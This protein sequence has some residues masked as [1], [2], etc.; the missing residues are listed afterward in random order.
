M[1]N[2]NAL[3]ALANAIFFLM[4]FIVGWHSFASEDY[5]FLTE[6]GKK[7]WAMAGLSLYLIILLEK[8]RRGK[9]RE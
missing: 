6:M 2:D 8:R 1:K 3:Y 9:E 4:A 5:R 7:I